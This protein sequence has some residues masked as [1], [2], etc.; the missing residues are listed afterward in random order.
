MS[1]KG[2]NGATNIWELKYV[3]R[4]ENT[5]STAG[6]RHT[7]LEGLVSWEG[8]ESGRGLKVTRAYREC[9]LSTK[10]EIPHFNQLNPSSASRV[11]C[12]T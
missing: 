12:S 9:K 7:V 2:N 3:A 10:R 4:S 8:E 11:S 1:W 6:L 5:C